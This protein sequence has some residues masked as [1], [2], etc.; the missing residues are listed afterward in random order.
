MFPV[1][2]IV[3]PLVMSVENALFEYRINRIKVFVKT[4]IMELFD[5]A[6]S[7]G[8]GDEVGPPDKHGECPQVAMQ[9]KYPSTPFFQASIK[10]PRY[11]LHAGRITKPSMDHEIR[12]PAGTKTTWP[13]QR[14]PLSFLI[15]LLPCHPSITPY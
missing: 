12:R 4:C 2:R 7:T 1:L 15:G 5:K 10:K 3:T 6:C 13:L 11:A 9:G 8:E 14:E